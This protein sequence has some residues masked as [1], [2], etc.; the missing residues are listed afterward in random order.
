[1]S[2][3]CAEDLGKKKQSIYISILGKRTHLKTTL[4][5]PNIQKR[6]ITLIRL[7]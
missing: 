1:M 5:I 7:D 3:G 2:E 4:S 6:P